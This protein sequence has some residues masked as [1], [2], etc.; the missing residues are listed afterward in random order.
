[1]NKSL[2]KIYFL[3]TLLVSFGNAVAQDFAKEKITNDNGSVS[4]VVFK[5]NAQL[6][7]IGAPDIFKTVLKL[8][9]GEVLKFISSNT[10][11]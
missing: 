8:K 10:D 6:K 4:L 11:A 3:G 5:K 7:S 9:D 1:M 2:L